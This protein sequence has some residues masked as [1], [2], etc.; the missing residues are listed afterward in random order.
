MPKLPK[1]LLKLEK[2]SLE[3]FECDRSR[4]RAGPFITPEFLRGC[5]AVGRCGGGAP[6]GRGYGGALLRQPYEGGSA[7]ARVRAGLGKRGIERNNTSIDIQT[8]ITLDEN[9]RI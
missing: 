8:L 4:E 5:A 2:N 9:D 6:P 3:F 1:G 7:H